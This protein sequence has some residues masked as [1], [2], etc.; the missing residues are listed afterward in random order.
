MA[1][2]QGRQGAE[3][4]ARKKV[5]RAFKEG[6]IWR[7]KLRVLAWLMWILLCI[8]WTSTNRV[9]DGLRVAILAGPWAIGILYCSSDWVR[10]IS[11]VLMLYIWPQW[12]MNFLPGERSVRQYV[13]KYGVTHTRPMEGGGSAVI[14]TKYGR[15]L[16]SG[17][18]KVITDAHNRHQSW[19]GQFT[20]EDLRMS[21]HRCRIK[22]EPMC[23]GS[24]ANLLLDLSTLARLLL[25][26]EFKDASGYPISYIQELYNLM[27][28]PTIGSYPSKTKKERFLKLL[29]GHPAIKSPRAV[30]TLISAIFQAYKS[31]GPTEKKKVDHIVKTIILAKDW[32]VD[33]LINTL[34]CKVLL[35]KYNYPANTVT[36]YARYSR[37]LFRFLRNFQQHGG[38]AN[39]HDGGQNITNLEELEYIASYNFST[40]IS[41][42]I[43]ELVMELDMQGML[44]YAWENYMSLA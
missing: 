7:L 26:D 18:I 12:M 8:E 16:W 22:R 10:D 2:C 40:F 44:Q 17:F 41:M 43:E 39:Q 29:H 30:T 33:A 15:N 9:H 3:R 23:I 25:V 6:A 19:G 35:F 34:L 38:D 31:M 27:I 28:S 4:V 32:R 5:A 20:M 24:F 14:C 21:G 42:L 37:D 36:S 1:S 13:S 11:W